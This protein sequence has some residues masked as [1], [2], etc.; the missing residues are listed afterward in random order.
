MKPLFE[1]SLIMSIGVIVVACAFLIML[2][3]ANRQSNKR[4]QILEAIESGSQEFSWNSRFVSL[5]SPSLTTAYRE[6]SLKLVQEDLVIIRT[7]IAGGA[8]MDRE[9]RGRLESLESA[10]TQY[11][12][13]LENM[14]SDPAANRAYTGIRVAL[15][16]L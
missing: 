16:T 15:N 2:K 11:Q 9:K 7:A 6:A 4:A 8:V 14:P 12:Y 1:L 10:Y 3:S 5:P 13:L